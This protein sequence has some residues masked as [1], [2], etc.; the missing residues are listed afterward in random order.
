MGAG[1]G[2]V[3]QI[4]LIT[5]AVPQD[6]ILQ[7]GH[8][9][10]G[11]S[12]DDIVILQCPEDLQR[13]VQPLGIGGEHRQGC[14]Q[15]IGS[16]RCFLH[17]HGLGVGGRVFQGDA[18]NLGIVGCN[19]ASGLL[20]HAALGA[21]QPPGT[22]GILH[23]VDNVLFFDDN[24]NSIRKFYTEAHIFHIGQV[25]LDLCSGAGSAEGQEVIALLDIGSLTNRPWGIDIG[26]G[27]GD[28]FD[29]E[30]TED[31]EEYYSY[32]EYDE[33]NKYDG[34]NEYDK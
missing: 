14:T 32:D 16:Q 5:G 17:G 33:S 34:S 26:A 28:F 8:I 11:G 30:E 19:A 10:T 6:D 18:H 2:C 15:L 7:V 13:N 23:G 27:H 29:L 12:T 31:G 4:D 3:A 24:I 22:G 1:V 9:H 21:D 20:N 25:G